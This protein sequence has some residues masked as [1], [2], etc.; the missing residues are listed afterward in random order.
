M[1]PLLNL[2]HEKYARTYAKTMNGTDAYKAAYPKVTHETADAH[3]YQLVGNSGV[4]SRIVELLEEKGFDEDGLTEKH[5]QLLNGK[6]ESTQLGALKLAYEIREDIKP[7]GPPVQV[8]VNVDEDG[9]KAIN[10]LLSTRKKR[11]DA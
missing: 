2:K 7:A 9:L 4:R 5:A 6:R 11:I 10:D 3:G 8:N 1:P